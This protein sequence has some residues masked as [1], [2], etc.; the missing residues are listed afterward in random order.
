MT[1]GQIITTIFEALLI[2]GIILGMI[3]EYKLIAFE[4]KLKKKIKKFLEVM[5]K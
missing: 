1:T 2:V 3:F 5:H 4:N